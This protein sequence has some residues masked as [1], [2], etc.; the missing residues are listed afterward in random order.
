MDD[1]QLEAYTKKCQEHLAGLEKQLDLKEGQELWAILDELDQ[2]L[3]K[4]IA[5]KTKKLK[6]NGDW[7]AP[8][9]GTQAGAGDDAAAEESGKEKEGQ[10]AEGEEKEEA[11]E[12]EECGDDDEEQGKSDEVKGEG[13]GEGQEEEEDPVVRDEWRLL[14][15]L[16]LKKFIPKA[17]KTVLRKRYTMQTRQRIGQF[18]QNVLRIT[19]LHIITDTKLELVK[20]LS[21]L[22]DPELVFYPVYPSYK[23]GP[24]GQMITYSDAHAEQPGDYATRVGRISVF[25]VDNL[26]AFGVAGGFDYIAA[27]LSILDRPAELGHIIMLLEPLIMVR[28]SLKWP[29]ARDWWSKIQPFVFARV[30]GMD[31]KEFRAVTKEEISRV[32]LI[33]EKLA[34][35]LI[36]PLNKVAGRE[37]YAEQLEKFKLALAHKCL[38]SSNLEKRL[39]GINTV[40]TLINEAQRK[41]ENKAKA[42]TY[43]SHYYGRSMLKSKSTKWLTTAYVVGW[44][45]E[46]QVVELL[47]GKGVH[48]ELISRSKDILRVLSEFRRFGEEHI[49]LMWSA[50]VGKGKQERIT[51]TIYDLFDHLTKDLEPELVAFLV[52]KIRDTRVF[53]VKTLNLMKTLTLHQLLEDEDEERCI[54]GLQLYW[55]IIQ[56]DHF[57]SREISEEAT[58]HLKEIVVRNRCEK[59]RKNFTAMCTKNIQQSSSVPQSLKLLLEIFDTFPASGVDEDRGSLIEGLQ[60]DFN[61]IDLFFTDLVIYKQKALEKIEK[62]RKESALR[63]NQAPSSPSLRPEA[64]EEL[65]LGK[66]TLVG[67]E[68]HTKQIKTRLKFLYYILKHSTLT[69]PLDHLNTLW[70]CVIGNGLTPKEKDLGLNWLIKACGSRSVF[71]QSVMEEATKLIFESKLCTALDHASLSLAGLTCFMEYFRYHNCA[72]GKLHKIIP[73]WPRGQS[74]TYIVRNVDL[75]G[76]K[77]LWALVLRVADEEVAVDAIAELNALYDREKLSPELQRRI[78]AIRDDYISTIMSHL[79]TANAA[80]SEASNN[81]AVVRRCLTLLTTFLEE[82]DLQQAG[83]ALAEPEDELIT[84]YFYA[85]RGQNRFLLEVSDAISLRALKRQAAKEINRSVNRIVFQL[86]VYSSRDEDAAVD[87]S[88]SLRE[89]GLTDNHTIYYDLVNDNIEDDDDDDT[90]EEEAVTTEAVEEV[91]AV[92][93]VV[94]P[95]SFV[96]TN[97]QAYFKLLFGLLAMDE[98][99]AQMAWDLLAKLPTNAAMEASIAS[100]H[101]AAQAPEWSE[102]IDPTSAF[103]LLYALRIVKAA[104]QRDRVTDDAEWSL[105]LVAQGGLQH[106]ADVLYRQDQLLRGNLSKHCLLALLEIIESTIALPGVPAAQ[107]DAAI[108]SERLVE[109]LQSVIRR[110]AV[111]THAQPSEVDGQVVKSACA[112][113]VTFIRPSTLYKG[114]GRHLLDKL[115]SAAE[116]TD[117]LRVSLLDSADTVIRV[118]VADLILTLYL[119][120]GEEN[121]KYFLVT[122]FDFLP[123]IAPDSQRCSEFFIVLSE[124]TKQYR[125]TE[126][127]ADQSSLVEPLVRTLTS[128]IKTHP[129]VEKAENSQPDQVLIGLLHIFKELAEV[130]PQGIKQR[131]EDGGS[132]IEE[133]FHK[134]LFE[135]PSAAFHGSLAPP[136]CKTKAS[137]TAAFA[138]LVELLKGSPENHMLVLGLVRKF[139]L[140]EAK[141]GEI[142]PL[143]LEWNHSPAAGERSPT[144]YVGLKNLGCT[145]YMNSLLQQF[146]MMPDFREGILSIDFPTDYDLDKALYAKKKTEEEEEEEDDDGDDADGAYESDVVEDSYDDEM[147]IKNLFPKKRANKKKGPVVIGSDDLLVEMQVM[148]GCLQESLRQYYNPKGF[149]FANKDYDGQPVDTSVQMDVDEFFNML[150][151]K[152]ETKLKGTPQEK[153]LKDIWCG[154]MSTQLICKGCPHRSE[155]DE[156]F[157]T[158]SLDIQNKKDIL[159]ALQLY[160]RGDMLEGD[161]AYF[162]E[163]CKKHVD[164]LKR[165]CIKELPNTMILH[166]KRFEFNLDTMRKVKLNDYCEFPDVLD[167]LPY[168]R[169]GLALQESQEEK[170]EGAKAQESS[171][172]ESVEETDEA[173]PGQEEEGSKTPAPAEEAEQ[174]QEPLPEIRPREYYEYELVGI[175]VHRGVADSG[176]YYSFIKDRSASGAAGESSW[177]E[178]NDKTV[179]EFAAKDIPAECYGGEETLLSYDTFTRTRLPRNFEKT[180]NAYMLIYQRK[181]PQPVGSSPKDVDANAGATAVAVAAQAEPA[182]QE[183]KARGCSKLLEHVWKDNVRF[184]HEKKLF[185]PAYFSFLWH[186]IDL[187]SDSSLPGL[188]LR[189]LQVATF[190]FLEV[191]SHAKDREILPRFGDRLR[192]RYKES[193]EASRWLVALLI[194]DKRMLSQL[195]FECPVEEIRSSFAELLASVVQTLL[196][197]PLEQR[198]LLQSEYE[199]GDVKEAG[200]PLVRPLVDRVFALLPDATRYWRQFKEYFGFFLEFASIGPVPKRYLLAMN[201]IGQFLHAYLGPNSPYIKER[202]KFKLGNRW[203]DPDYSTLISC[204][205]LLA[206]SCDLP[207]DQVVTRHQAAAGDDGDDGAA[208]QDVLTATRYP[209]TQEEGEPLMLAGWDYTFLANESFVK[210]LVKDDNKYVVA[211]SGILLRHLIWENCTN[212]D[213][214]MQV[215]R[216]AIARASYDMLKPLLAVMEQLLAVEDSYTAT[217][218]ENNIKDLLE[219]FEDKKKLPKTTEINIKF[220]IHKLYEKNAVARHALNK[221]YLNTLEA[222]YQPLAWVESW[223]NTHHHDINDPGWLLIPVSYED[224][225]TVEDF[226][227]TAIDADA[228]TDP[229]ADDPPYPPGSTE[230]IHDSI[231]QL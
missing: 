185:D 76:L 197:D 72:Q 182:Q 142:V 12:K 2:Y 70:D 144:G 54:G 127:E 83:E 160:V 85:A 165:S 188:S 125:S 155:R 128:L 181:V 169:E 95:P 62:N 29:F 143:G 195:L 194:D 215:M 30:I 22:F 36:D 147:V 131:T 163:T 79:E 60:Q 90:D 184:L 186:L 148:F 156:Q 1:L 106:L 110:S 26:N 82:L 98:Q 77:A 211:E 189:T 81:T 44:L 75:I 196:K 100:F 11:Q 129:I 7:P 5:L 47:F 52:Q 66:Q 221:L 230:F 33:V 51:D 202:P 191:I 108:D 112:L 87:D 41:D 151:D 53:D 178:F 223:L 89:L 17:C 105:Q 16:L 206:R 38:H 164:T 168:T 115:T 58:N 18:L 109:G 24:A 80:Q 200:S 31:E 166:L 170:E 43:T 116:F 133:L 48:F 157:Y 69:L 50:A 57:I 176:H 8:P 204:V 9:L 179:T 15:R 3:A 104:L 71:D 209:P 91:P 219:I 130:L 141:E 229:A 146:F 159:E 174:A 46:K 96:L 203:E 14:I 94:H 101:T 32:V 13:D 113:L 134:C 123:N 121:R 111:D 193:D 117:L 56:D 208:P 65:D 119:A 199:M 84:L 218:V 212:T 4:A 150:C 161:N 201:A 172:R 152:L 64:K 55:D 137:R 97:N 88:L 225:N 126:G 224:E 19:A 177:I 171:P 120:G 34:K 213:V 210:Q 59:Y 154:K 192:Q 217:R 162:C 68:P 40:T 92:K 27:R 103:S 10:A 42:A 67:V 114:R 49:N 136:K 140:N 190:F 37:T 227:A 214:V 153:L 198:A 21:W 124:L 220:L 73:S 107:I 187:N 93:A 28:K 183:P 139:H 63:D 135:V 118:E 6:Q 149:C 145:C 132:L 175:L 122:L 23:M 102:L 138:L 25:M 207:R 20:N 86:S 74:P 173:A 61:I 158:M 222:N 167:M 180:R 78:G 35:L 216:N 231:D 39:F 45:E 205:S 228:D 226:D 99:V